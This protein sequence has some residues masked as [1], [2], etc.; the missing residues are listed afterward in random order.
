MIGTRENQVTLRFMDKNNDLFNDWLA[1]RAFRDSS[2]RTYSA[3]FGAV[4]A[5][6]FEQD[7]SFLEV[8]PDDLERFFI[9]RGV[10]A[11][12]ERRYLL[13][14][15][16]YFNYLAQRRV[17]RENPALPLLA[18]RAEDRAFQPPAKSGPIVLE[19]DEVR[20]L[21]LFAH[22]ES[23]SRGD[24]RRKAIVAVLLGCGLTAKEV[25]ELRWASLSL[26]GRG[27]VLRVTGAGGERKVPIPEDLAAVLLAW[28]AVSNAHD[29]GAVDAGQY[30][31]AKGRARLPYTAAGVFRVVQSV[32]K[33]AGIV[34]PRLS[35][36]VLRNTFAARNLADEV[37][38]ETVQQ[39][40]GHGS[41]ATTA[42][43]R[44]VRARPGK[45]IPRGISK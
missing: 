13:L 20:R 19:D 37:P 25:C 5:W 14:L 17:V 30:V 8:S 44:L 23:L 32:L 33:N 9:A 1:L 35:P 24:M 3:M 38:L 16:D 40:L 12:T 43:Y 41:V 29:E 22:E 18:K 7:I 36:S 6:L 11:G 45:N 21:D 4:S 31:F 42:I 2:K 39:W 28:R 27:D 34:K 26:N 15:R 10:K